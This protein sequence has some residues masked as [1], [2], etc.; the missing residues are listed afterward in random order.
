MGLCAAIREILVRP[1]KIQSDLLKFPFSSIL[2]RTTRPLGLAHL[3]PPPG[4]AH[5]TPVGAG[6]PAVSKHSVGACV[7][8][9]GLW[10]SAVPGPEGK[11][12]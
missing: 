4:A 9:G 3:T 7:V 1:K 2:L 12:G 6:V 8:G 10:D 5:Y 11:G